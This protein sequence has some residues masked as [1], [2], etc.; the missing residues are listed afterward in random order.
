MP[1]IYHL[2]NKAETIISFSNGEENKLMA[3]KLIKSIVKKYLKE[4]MK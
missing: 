1:V 3:M 2:S 4:Q